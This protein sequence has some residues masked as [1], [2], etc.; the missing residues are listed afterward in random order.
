M[1]FWWGAKVE[2]H[3]CYYLFN[4]LSIHTLYLHSPQYSKNSILDQLRA[5]KGV[6]EY[7][8]FLLASGGFILDQGF[9]V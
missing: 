4:A 2:D 3:Y 7:R 8:L 5:R 1:E 9:G 6:E